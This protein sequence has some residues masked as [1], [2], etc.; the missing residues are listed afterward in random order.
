M[1][2]IW[3]FESDMCKGYYSYLFNYALNSSSL[4]FPRS[5]L[6]QIFNYFEKLKNLICLV[7][8]KI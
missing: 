2:E 3:T 8:K 5:K 4:E 6:S 7:D 1:D